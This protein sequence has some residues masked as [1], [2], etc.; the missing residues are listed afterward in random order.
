MNLLQLFFCAA[1]LFAVISASDNNA[2][3]IKSVQRSKCATLF[4]KCVMKIAEKIDVDDGFKRKR[5]KRSFM[6][7]G[8]SPCPEG[9]I[10]FSYKCWPCDK[11][12]DTT[13]NKCQ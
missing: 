13:G 4:G 10:W 5:V 3:E 2:G 9:H 11:Y 7:S 6:N 8:P 12:E 1:V